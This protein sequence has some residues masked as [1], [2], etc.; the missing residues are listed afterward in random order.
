MTN[1]RSQGSRHLSKELLPQN[2]VLLGGRARDIYA[3]CPLGRRNAIGS[4]EDGNSNSVRAEAIPSCP[5]PQRPWF[6]LQT[7]LEASLQHEVGSQQGAALLYGLWEAPPGTHLGLTVLLERQR[8]HRN[9]GWTHDK[10]YSCS[11]EGV[12]RP[13]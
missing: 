6:G 7:P 5:S 11:H 12:G 9:K 8:S 3:R 4:L 10:R 2:E 13:S 1:P